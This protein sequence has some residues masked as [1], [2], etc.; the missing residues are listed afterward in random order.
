MSWLW[1]GLAAWIGAALAAVTWWARHRSLEKTAAIEQQL[2]RIGDAPSSRD[3]AAAR[4]ARLRVV[5]AAALRTNI[6]TQP[7]RTEDNQ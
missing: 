1:W 6:P 5:Q 4:N 7:R 2:R 3:L